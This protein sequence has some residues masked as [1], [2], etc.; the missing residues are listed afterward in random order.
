M[1]RSPD[2]HPILALCLLSASL[3][4][5]A[6]LDSVS[7]AWEKEL[8][9]VIE[10]RC[11]D[12][13]DA[14]VMK[15]DVDLDLRQP[16]PARHDVKLWQKVREQ[17]RAG[18]MPPAGKPP[19]DAVQ[20][21]L[22]LRWISQNEQAVLA[23][24]EG[25]PGPAR[26]RRLNR[27]EYSNTLRDLLGVASRPG[28]RFPADGAGGEGFANSADTLSLSTLLVEKQLEAARAAM[29]EVYQR[30]ELLAKLYA[31]VKS[32]KL[33]PDVGAELALRPFLIRAFRRP[34]TESEVQTVLAV[35]RAAWQRK[36]NWDSA[37]KQMFQAVLATPAFLFIQE[38]S[39]GQGTRQLT[40]YEMASSLSYFL[41]SSMPDD[42][43]LA[44]AAQGRLQDGGVLEAQVRRMILDAKALA[45]TKSFAGQWLRFGE[46]HNSVEPDL[47]KFPHF[48][49]DIRQAM[50]D[51]AFLFCDTLLRQDG[52]VL[53]LLDCNYT[54]VNEALARF[55]DLP[56]VQGK[57]LRRVSFTDAKRG[58]ITS[59]GAILASTSY[60]QRTS[61]VLRGKWILE[62]LLGTP[63][64][65]PPPDVGSL[66]E[67]D[68]SIADTT[69]RKRLE[70]H[71]SKPVCAG[72]HARLDPPGFALENFDPVGK[73]RDQEN[74]KPI[75]ASGSMPGGHGF[76][77]P[78]QFRKLL[79]DD[80]ALFVRSLC[81]R[82]LGYALGR[83]VE[84]DD[85]P[86]LLKM[87]Q[88]LRDAD[89]HS[90]PLILTV[91]KSRAFR[92]RS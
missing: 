65:P 42:E 88:S 30:G 71:R 87:E 17:L 3:V 26:A 86:T 57:E 69:L 32:D 36:P 68:R 2:V 55:Y 11:L 20:R 73:W 82:L 38:A 39:T 10:Q 85:Q 34:P 61:P 37:M 16:S 77:T 21:E 14:D 83:G 92:E 49:H 15:G 70:A 19:L 64:P 48:T 23:M 35:F 74:G 50:H 40:S 72:C 75:D 31:P 62:T 7:Q 6:S 60:P 80:K 81:T 43:L 51:E 18:T 89:Y 28:D 58:G 47:G 25:K 91:V 9:P 76:S 45:F 59:M 1:L 78:A 56:G 5:A 27:E 24:A 46:I 41:W 79:M 63:P 8:L 54:F 29:D 53:D 33:A 90:L 12:C 4:H 84:L 13:H 52:R 67:D 22:M 44:L 66:P